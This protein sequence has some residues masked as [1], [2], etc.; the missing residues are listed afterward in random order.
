MGQRM[1]HGALVAAG[2]LSPPGQEPHDVL[3]A[4]GAGG[5]RHACRE[6]L[7]LEA[8]GGD[9][10]MHVLDGDAG[11]ALG[12][13]HCRADAGFGAV[14][15]GDHAGL[16]TFGTGMVEAQHLELNALAAALEPIGCGRSLGDQTADLA[17]TDIERGDDAL[18]LAPDRCRV[19]HPP[20]LF[21]G[22]AFARHS[23]GARGRNF[24]CGPSVGRGRV[25]FLAE[26]DGNAVE[27]PEIDRGDVAL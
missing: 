8:A 5:Q 17:R 7:A 18:A 24:R 3:L 27:Q 1:Q 25:G 15:M 16:E 21:L 13:I 12:G 4:H 19:A 22:L 26:P 2:I 10:H 20:A 9:G 6:A 23:L 14:E 11:H